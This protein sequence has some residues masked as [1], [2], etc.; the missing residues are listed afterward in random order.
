MINFTR[1]LALV[2]VLLL[3]AI[4][5]PTV[6]GTVS[7]AWDPVP[8]ADLQGYRVY[9]GTSPSSYS[10]S[11]DVQN[12]TQATISGL[13][14][15][16][17][18]YFG[19]KA[20][21]TAGNQS[22]TF[23]NQLQGWSR[24]VVSAATPAA[25]EAGRSLSVTIAGSN[26][27][28]GAAALFSN[29]GVTVTS[30]TVNACGQLTLNVTVANNAAVG[31]SSVDVT[32]ADGVYGTGVGIFSVQA[33]V[34][35]TVSS[36]TP[37]NGASGVSVAV[38]PTVTFSEAMS[39]SSITAT[40]VRLLDDT[41]ATVA[42]AAG[43]PSLSGNGLTATITP[44]VNLTQGETYRIQVVSGASG[45]LDLAN[46]GMTAT[47]TQATGFSTAADS[48][49][50]T[51]SSLASTAV[52]GTT[53][54]ITWTTS[55]S[56]NGQVFFR[57]LGDAA[58]QQTAIDATFVISHSTS[59]AGLAP[60]TTYEYYVQSADSAGNTATSTP[61][62][63]FVTAANGFTYLRF[64]AESGSMIS[65]V[66]QAGSGSGGFGEAYI[67]TPS[68][69]ATGSSSSPAGTATFGVNVPTAGSWRLWV[70]MYGASTSNDSWYESINA[71]SRQQVVPSVAG[72]WQW[73][74]GRTYTLGAGLST[75]ELGGREAQARIDRVLLT[76]DLSFTPTEQAVG[77]QTPPTADTGFTAVG[78]TSQVTL[79]WT[80][81]SSVDFNR[82]IVRYRTDGKF[83]VSPVDGFAVVTKPGVPGSPD[84]F[85]HIGL[86]TGTTY[87]YSAFAVDAAG[88]AAA[89]VNA[90]ATTQ[91]A[92]GPAAVQNLRRNDRR[93]P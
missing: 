20:Y 27:A 17:T 61:I 87:S 89:D 30:T 50:P 77:D 73:V 31:V 35:P 76:D 6:A 4:G 15:C 64:E 7:I 57:R 21:D 42:Q 13:T 70:R 59:L 44:A 78:T 74:S 37:S 84:T 52:G 88:N 25:V 72:Q 49:A 55:E 67:D 18:Y 28:A 11:V 48:G 47:M 1:A 81:S 58:Y 33:A 24:P 12:V 16:T 54:T 2:A 63:T 36:T 75:L 51:I 65:P 46:H 92:V 10:Q 9:Y 41:G 66:R 82:T 83:P 32:N 69:T 19:V 60:G 14:D 56:A 23:S 38:K 29:A 93:T 22:T 3:A 45:V 62:K 34:S 5:H 85:V 53:A 26:F 91:D 71:A 43:S 68:G 79:S 39:P 80:N 86:T 40:T 8:D 90:S